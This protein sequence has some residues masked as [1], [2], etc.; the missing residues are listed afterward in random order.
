MEKKRKIKE[1]L[2][3]MTGGRKDVAKI[4]PLKRLPVLNGSC[5]T[6]TD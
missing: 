6:P 5:D 3:K 2:V 4:P 1:I